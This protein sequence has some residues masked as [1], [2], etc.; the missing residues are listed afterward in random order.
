MNVLTGRL[1][2]IT[3]AFVDHTITIAV[4]IAVSWAVA[5]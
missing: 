3:Y 1:L 4:S 2:N 5:Y